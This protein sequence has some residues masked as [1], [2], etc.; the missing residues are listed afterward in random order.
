MEKKERKCIAVVISKPERKYQ[1]G[2]IKGICNA[3]FAKGMNV[4]VFAT[5]LLE[6]MEEYVWGEEE[7]FKL[8]QFEKFAGIIY[9][10]GSFY[11]GEI[12]Q[13]LNKR[14]REVA[15]NGTPVVAVDGEVEGLPSL[16][17]DDSH[18]VVDVIDHLVKVHRLKDIAYMTGHKGHP[19]AENSL[20]SYRETMA[21]YGFTVS[22]DRVYYGD[23]WYNE[24]ENFVNQ[25]EKSGNGYPEAIVCANEYMAIGIYKALYARE[26]YMPKDIR[27]ACT[28]NDSSNAPYLLTGENSLEIVGEE[29]CKIIFSALEGD[30]PEPGVKLFPSKNHLI[31][32]VGCGCQKSSAYNY[33]NEKGVQLDIDAGYLGELNFAR[34]SMLFM[35]DY[36]SL[37]EALENNFQHFHNFKELH[38]CMCDGWD[39][40]HL[41][42]N[43]IKKNTY[44]DSI[45][46]FYSRR[47]TEE[48]PKVTIGTPTYFPK[49]DMFP[50]LFVDE[51]EP[52]VYVFHPLHYLDRNYGYVVLNNGQSPKA[53]EYTFNFWLHDIADGVESLC[54][55]R[56]VNYMFYTDVMTGLY[57]R[58]GFNTMLSEIIEEAKKED[59]SILVALADM[60]FLKKIN[61]TYG[62]SEGDAAIKSAASILKKTAVPCA[63]L[64]KNFRIGGDEFVKIAIGDFSEKCVAKFKET[65]YEAAAEHTRN[66]DKPYVIQMSLGYCMG[67]VDTTEELES[68]LSKADAA[69]YDEK[70]RLKANRR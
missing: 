12:T 46:L 30:K 60:N 4:A 7:I 19:H 10:V 33:S 53:Y 38:I 61:D 20:R 57:N 18:A 52:S 40:P 58:N 43:D 50:G 69:M 11:G 28:S 36:S 2:L 14:L 63:V 31:T 24:S 44:T 17:V 16:F 68:F 9:A 54:R 25:L 22:E 42:I 15:E 65:L 8:V 49:E 64:E 13:K 21:K 66:S 59:K 29:A 67:K 55:L 35:K 6:G 70:V 26:V 27:I 62:H 51:G 32:S 48:G 5:S 39:D 1:E 3:A 45:Q 37:V 23:Y 56:S 41:I 47:V 34:E